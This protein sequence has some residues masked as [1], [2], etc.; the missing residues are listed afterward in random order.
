[1][2]ILKK[3]VC[4]KLGSGHV[5]DK[6]HVQTLAQNCCKIPFLKMQKA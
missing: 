4:S 6:H 5:D 1:M 3:K 2:I